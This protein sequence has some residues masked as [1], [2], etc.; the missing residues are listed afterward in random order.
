MKKTDIPLLFGFA[1]VYDGLLG[2]AFLLFPLQV[3]NLFGVAR[4][5]HL[6]YIQFP[7]LVLLIFAVM[8]IQIAADP[9]VY[10]DLIPYGI[11]FKAAYCLVVFGWWLYANIP[12]MW[13][14]FAVADLVFLILFAR[15]YAEVSREET[16]SA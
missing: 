8:F 7:A 10:R 11:M 1:A 12:Y 13:K 3:F 5:N 15:A 6:G 4:P 9:K 14:P 16:S 2:I